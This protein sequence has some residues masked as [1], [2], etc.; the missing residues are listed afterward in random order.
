MKG[1]QGNRGLPVR[2]DRPS[3]LVPLAVIS[4]ILISPILISRARYRLRVLRVPGLK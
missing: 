1:H 3:S 2:C 4:P